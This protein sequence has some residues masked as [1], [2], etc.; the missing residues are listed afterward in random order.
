MLGIYKRRENY[1]LTLHINYDVLSNLGGETQ[2]FK[3]IT[4]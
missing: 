4:L 1:F 2:S 3:K